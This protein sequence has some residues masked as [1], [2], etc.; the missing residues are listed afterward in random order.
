MAKNKRKAAAVVAEPDGKRKVVP[1][2]GPPVPMVKP[3][4][5][6]LRFAP[7][8]SGRS[9]MV[10]SML[11]KRFQREA[12]AEA[13]GSKSRGSGSS[14]GKNEHELEDATRWVTSTGMAHYLTLKTRASNG[15]EIFFKCRPTTLL[16]K[17]MDAYCFRANVDPHTVAFFKADE[18]GQPDQQLLGSSTPQSVGLEDNDV[19]HVIDVMF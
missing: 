9:V 6:L 14:S 18:D 4:E 5:K 11:A 13:Q 15:M 10:N 19:I 1:C 7:N 8:L 3:S 17:L 12:A 16:E 2:Q